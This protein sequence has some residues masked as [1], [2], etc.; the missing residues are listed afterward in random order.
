MERE[1][2]GNMDY[3]KENL[4]TVPKKNPSYVAYERFFVLIAPSPVLEYK[5]VTT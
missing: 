5:E 2:K 4:S 1:M 3:K